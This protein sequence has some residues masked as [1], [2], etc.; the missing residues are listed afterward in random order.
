MALFG[1][2]LLSGC[3]LFGG[4][5]AVA[6]YSL[7]TTVNFALQNSPRVKLAQADLNRAQAVLSETKDVFIPAISATAGVGN[8]I[9]APLSPPVVFSI[10]AQSLVFNFSQRDYIRAARS[11]VQSAELA[12]QVARTDVS[13]DTTTTYVA[14]DNALQRRSV[15]A[16]ALN[17]ARRLVAI[18]EE[19]YNAGVDPHIELT[20]ARRTAAQLRLQQLEVEDEIA[21]DQEHLAS[22]TALPTLGWMTVHD[23]IPTFQLPG[24]PG[25]PDDPNKYVGLDA[26]FAAAQAKQ[27]TA[28]GDKHYVLLPQ[29]SFGANYSRITDAFNSYVDYYPQSFDYPGHSYNS[30]S[31][32]LQLTVPLL[33]MTHKARARQAAADAAH[34]LF[35]ARI[36]QATFIESRQKLRHS[37][38]EL[39]AHA[40]LASLDHDLAQD[41]LDAVLVQWQ[42]AQ[43]A[44]GGTQL[45]PKDEQNARLA[46]RQ[47]TGDMLKAQLDLQQAEI[48]LLRQEGSLANWLAATVPGS[49]AAPAGASPVL[50]PQLPPSVVGPPAAPFAPGAAQP[51]APTNGSPPATLPGSPV[52]NPT[53][54]PTPSTPS[55]P[56]QTPSSTPRGD[57]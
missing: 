57:G 33:D 13:E 42:A 37:A 8:A 2:L 54:S 21:A 14:L 44:S 34:S 30:L 24:T 12:L 41:Q 56:T 50:Q 15:Q 53:P 45:S 49:T 6:Q 10:G 43:G 48:S 40:D 3:T 17:F 28:R 19:R 51:A 11:G 18:V 31:F 4:T 9:G 36:Q 39:A 16:D 7:S 1:G 46:E 47:R 20:R 26:G 23:S 5:A 22:L 55:T 38:Q 25:A 52:T 29:A 32:D 35:E 27:F